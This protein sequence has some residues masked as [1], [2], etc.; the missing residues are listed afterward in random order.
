MGGPVEFE[1]NLVNNEEEDKILGIEIEGD[2][3]FNIKDEVG[4]SEIEVSE[5]KNIEISFKFIIRRE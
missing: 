2:I 5:N 1:K 4:N 3:Q